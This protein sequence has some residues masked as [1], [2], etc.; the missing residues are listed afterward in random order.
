MQSWLIYRSCAK[1]S[2]ADALAVVDGGSVDKAKLDEAVTEAD[3]AND[4][5]IL[6]VRPLFMEDVMSR[7]LNL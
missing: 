7:L 1:L 2:Y 4:I 6:H 5:R 3:I